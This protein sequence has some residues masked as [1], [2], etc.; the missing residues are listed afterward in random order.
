MNKTIM[1]RDLELR[2]KGLNKK[3]RERIFISVYMLLPSYAPTFTFESQYACQNFIVKIS[4][5]HL[6]KEKYS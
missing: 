2:E 3:E 1:K 4:H 5:M 6:K